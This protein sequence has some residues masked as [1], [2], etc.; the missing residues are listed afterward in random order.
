MPSGHAQLSSISTAM[1][2]L[3]AR[4]TSIA[5]EYST[6]PREDLAADLYDVERSLRAARRRLDRVIHDLRMH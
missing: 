2:D 4:V 3:T 5:D 6:T 1:E